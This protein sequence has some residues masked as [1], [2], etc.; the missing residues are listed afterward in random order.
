MPCLLRNLRTFRH[1]NNPQVNIPQ[2]TYRHQ[3]GSYSI[4]FQTFTSSVA[5]ESEGI[6][7]VKAIFMSHALEYPEDGCNKLLLYVGIYVTDQTARSHL[8]C[9]HLTSRVSTIM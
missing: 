8:L 9:E 6:H 4:N 2:Y 7:R 5:G 1:L 3:H